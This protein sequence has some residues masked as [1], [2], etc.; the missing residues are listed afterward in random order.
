MCLIRTKHRLPRIVINYDDNAEN[1][2]YVELFFI[3]Y[4]YTVIGPADKVA[5]C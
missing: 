2:E 4:E 1:M 3:L 5:E